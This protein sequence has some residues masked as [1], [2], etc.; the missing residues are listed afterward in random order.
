MGDVLVVGV[1]PDE[2]IKRCKGPPVMSQEERCINRRRFI[3]NLKL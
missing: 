3:P 1:H 2:E